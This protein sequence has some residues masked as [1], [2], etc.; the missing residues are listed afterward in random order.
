MYLARMGIQYLF[1]PTYSPDLN[2]A[3]NCFSKLKSVLKME[4]FQSVTQANVKVAVGEALKE[5]STTDI[6][7]YFRYTGYINMN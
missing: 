1:L 3:E 2:P 4:R 7:G 5:I 6:E